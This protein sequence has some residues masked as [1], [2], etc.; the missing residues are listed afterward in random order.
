MDVI[1]AAYY[2]ILQFCAMD[3]LF[4]NRLFYLI[5]VDVND[6][7]SL[8]KPFGNAEMQKDI[9]EK[10]YRCISHMWGTGDKTVDYVWKDHGIVGITWDVETRKEKRERLLQIFRYHKGYFW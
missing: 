3:I 7:T 9:Q 2:S 10:G 4:S 5:H 6:K 1:R 8:V